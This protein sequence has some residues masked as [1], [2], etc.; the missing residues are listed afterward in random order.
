[1]Q[2]ACELMDWTLWCWRCLGVLAPN[3]MRGKL[4]VRGW[5]DWG[6]GRNLEE[7]AC[8]QWHQRQLMGIIIEIKDKTRRQLSL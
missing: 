8:G 3:H 1:M 7:R 2:L 4:V 5:K 6:S